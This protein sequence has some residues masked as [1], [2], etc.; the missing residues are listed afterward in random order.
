MA[1]VPKPDEAQATENKSIWEKTIVSTPVILT[2]VATIL[3][4]LSNSELNLAQY[5]RGLAAQMQSKVSDQWAYFQAKRIRADQNDN[6]AQVLQSISQPAPFDPANLSAQLDRLVQELNSAEYAGGSAQSDPHLKRIRSLADQI[7]QAAT[8]PDQTDALARFAEGKVQH[9]P[10]QVIDDPQINEVIRGLGSH[11]SDADLENEAGKISLKTLTDAV[12]IANANI[13]A[14]D[15]ATAGSDK[16]LAEIEKLFSDLSREILAFEGSIGS[17]SA[18][19]SVRDAASQLSAGYTIARMKYNAS[20][21]NSDAH[22]NQALAQLYEVQVRVDGFDSDRHRQ[23]S[24]EFFY[25]MLAAQAGVTVATFALAVRRK[26]VLWSLAASA[27][28]AA[29]TFA[30]YVYVFV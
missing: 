3:A 6:S 13:A 17:G 7:R 2:V 20:R 1:D 16:S 25:G 22:Y 12:D 23:R 24:K 9:V 26:S 19:T 28:F 29:I 4:G 10:E 8:Q 15:A 11:V 5:Y 30:A 27:G 18:L 14:Y 21:Y